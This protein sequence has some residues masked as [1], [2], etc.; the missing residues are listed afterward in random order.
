MVWQLLN[1]ELSEQ[2]DNDSRQQA[3]IDL[4]SEHGHDR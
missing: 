4:S 3:E 2:L 1:P